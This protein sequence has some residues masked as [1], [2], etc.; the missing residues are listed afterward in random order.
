M[1]KTKEDAKIF[2]E[3]HQEFSDQDYIEGE[4]WYRYDGED[5][6]NG[7]PYT[8]NHETNG[9]IGVTLEQ[10]VSYVYRNRKR[11]NSIGK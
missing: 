7:K 6:L 8:I 11:L 5:T 3:S 2:L 10:A 4:F 1:I 9:I